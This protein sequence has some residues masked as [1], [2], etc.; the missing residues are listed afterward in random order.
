MTKI[1]DHVTGGTK[2]PR[3]D[4]LE[5]T[6]E[7][8]VQPRRVGLAHVVIEVVE[9]S[10]VIRASANVRASMGEHVRGSPHPTRSS[11]PVDRPTFTR[12]AL[13]SFG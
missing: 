7:G 1:R 10:R 12:L 4:R 5:A 2:A 13:N 8:V 6:L 9:E 3:L 11:A